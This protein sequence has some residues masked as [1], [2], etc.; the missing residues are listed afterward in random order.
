MLH[1][2]GG[3]FHFLDRRR[4]RFFLLDRL[5]FRHRDRFFYRLGG[6]WLLFRNRCRHHR[7]G[8]FR[9]RLLDLRF[10][11]LLRLRCHRFKLH[12]FLRLLFHWYRSRRRCRLYRRLVFLGIDEGVALDDGLMLRLLFIFV[13]LLLAVRLLDNLCYLD[14]HFLSCLLE[15]QV[16][17]ELSADGRHILVRDLAVWV[18]LDLDTYLAE[19]SHEIVK[20]DIELSYYLI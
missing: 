12:R 13:L 10:G 16:F 5:D 7:L 3:R 19:E 9:S 20:A 18:G 1:C 6:S 2:R 8:C 11:R 14:I 4:F 17:A 15:F